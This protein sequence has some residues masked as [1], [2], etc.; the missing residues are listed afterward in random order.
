MT[1]NFR[2][3]AVIPARA[4]SRGLPQKNQIFFDNTANF[5]DKISWFDEIVVNSN[6]SIVLDK[7]RSRNYTIYDRP[8]ILSGPKISIKSV[9]TDL[10][11]SKN[12]KKNEIIWLF[13]LPI[14]FKNTQ[15][16]KNAKIRIEQP[17][18]KS[19]CTFV[20]VKSHPFNAWKYDKKNKKINQYIKNDFY[21][22]QDLPSAWIH[23]HYVCCFKVSE[24]DKLNNELLNTETYPFFLSKEY[25]KN[26]IEIDTPEDLE[27]WN[28]VNN[29]T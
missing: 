24:I 20:P 29:K 6:D 22:R 23:Y 15:D 25:A 3:I 26:L 14:L 27:K 5:I 9:F 18:I 13:Y 28:L 17:D 19:L 2:H 12:L 4:G 1:K 11:N 21:R 10:I 16:F 8:E 7:A